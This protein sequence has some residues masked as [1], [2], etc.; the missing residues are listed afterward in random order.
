[1]LNAT[2]AFDLASDTVLQ[3]I[4]EKIRE[5]CGRGEFYLDYEGLIPPSVFKKLVTN[6]Y[7]ISPA[8]VG[9]VIMRISFI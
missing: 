5:A 1:M 2:E 4:E 9:G 3:A 7:W 6:G 8:P